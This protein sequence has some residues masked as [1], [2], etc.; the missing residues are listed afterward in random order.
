MNIS[1]EIPASFLRVFQDT[2]DMF[3]ETLVPMQSPL[4]M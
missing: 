2:R 3:S 4:E 1:E